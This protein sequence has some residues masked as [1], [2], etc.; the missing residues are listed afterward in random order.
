MT[1]QH[2]DVVATFSPSSAAAQLAGYSSYSPYGTETS[3]ANTEDL[4]YQGDYTDPS[5]G[6]VYMNARWYDPA[7]GSFVS[8]DTSNDATPIPFTVDG[9]PYAYADGNPVTR[10]DP[11]GHQIEPDEAYGDWGVGETPQSAFLSAEAG[12]AVE[13]AEQDIAESEYADYEEEQALEAGA[14]ESGSDDSELSELEEEE[15]EREVYEEDLAADDEGSRYADESGSGDGGYS[16]YNGYSGGGG[17]YAGS[18]GGYEGGGPVEAPAP[19]PPPQDAYTSGVKEI[20][21]A[22]KV[23]LSEPYITA[24]PTAPVDVTHGE[25]PAS[26]QITEHVTKPSAQDQIN[27]LKESPGQ[28]GEN[29]HATQAGDHGDDT[30]LPGKPVSEEG[31]PTTPTATAASPTAASPAAGSDSTGEGYAARVLS[32][33]LTGGGDAAT[34][35]DTNVTAA[36]DEAVSS[37]GTAS[38]WAG[39]AVLTSDGGLVISRGSEGI[40]APGSTSATP[41]GSELLDEEPSTATGVIAENQGDISDAFTTYAGSVHYDTRGYVPAAPDQVSA[42]IVTGAVL[43]AAAIEKAMGRL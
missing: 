33:L 13:A 7:V 4:G 2:G 16:G 8:N 6:L 31:K 34:L 15:Y 3:T 5:T 36:G 21:S 12:P 25:V 35:I 38:P 24:D 42:L 23:L 27:G 20:P 28:A 1:D 43:V 19:P 26:D 37:A 39:K 14:H 9:N 30:N 40:L 11:T 18:G 32:H 29:A 41:E 10:T 22:P 17:G